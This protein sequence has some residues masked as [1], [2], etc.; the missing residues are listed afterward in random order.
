MCMTLSYFNMTSLENFQ[1]IFSIGI[2]KTFLPI[3]MRGR[4]VHSCFVLLSK[5]TGSCFSFTVYVT[6]KA[7]TKGVSFHKI[8]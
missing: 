5:K 7:G 2:K 8:S 4:K 1:A 6:E 3:C